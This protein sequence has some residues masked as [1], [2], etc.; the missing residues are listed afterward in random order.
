MLFGDGVGFSGLFATHPPLLARIQALEPQFRAD[1]LDT[2]AQRWMTQPPNGLEEDLHLGLADRQRH[3]IAGRGVRV[4][5]HSADG[6][7]AGRASD[8]RRLPA[9]RRDRRWRS[10]KPCATWRRN[11]TR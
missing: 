5:R 9:R 3:A 1:Q 2:L 6:G 4:R 8:G 10:R 11:A 7:V